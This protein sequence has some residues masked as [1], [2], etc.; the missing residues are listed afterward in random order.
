[1]RLSSRSGSR[2]RWCCVSGRLSWPRPIHGL[3][4]HPWLQNRFRNLR[5]PSSTFRARPPSFPWHPCLVLQPLPGIWVPLQSPGPVLARATCHQL[6][7]GTGESPLS[8]RHLSPSLSSLWST[9]CRSRPDGFYQRAVK[10]G[11]LRLSPSTMATVIL[12]SA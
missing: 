1:M 8:F 9:G 11:L 5:R 2:H 7:L 3:S 10:K 4:V 12:L 6:R